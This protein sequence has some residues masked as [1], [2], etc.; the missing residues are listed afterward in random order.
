MANNRVSEFGRVSKAN[1]AEYIKGAKDETLSSR[2]LLKLLEKKGKITYGHS[3]EYLDWGVL[4]GVQDAAAITDGAELTISRKQPYDRA[5]L[6]WFGLTVNDAFTAKEKLMNAGSSTALIK[7]VQGLSDYIKKSLKVG[8]HKGLYL[9]GETTTNANKMHGIETWFNAATSTI[10]TSGITAAETMFGT[11]T[12]AGIRLDAVYNSNYYWL[13]AVIPDACDDG[14]WV[15]WNTSD[16]MQI[17]D[18][19]Q[20]QSMNR[21]DGKNA[22]CCIMGMT[23]YGLLRQRVLTMENIYVEKSGNGD[24]AADVG[25]KYVEFAGTPVFME[26][27]MPTAPRQGTHAAYVLQTDEIEYCVLGDEFIRVDIEGDIEA[28]LFTK[29]VGYHFG[30]LKTS[31]PRHQVKILDQS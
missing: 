5:Q 6:G 7:Y 30:Q 22:D 16:T 21:N 23:W 1:I 19:A 15:N 10:P 18:Y 8:I 17:L 25:F 20:L 4:K 14:V 3:G 9:N 13:P 24:T 12:Y 2:P 31:S 27:D 29:L 11:N 26:S 28:G